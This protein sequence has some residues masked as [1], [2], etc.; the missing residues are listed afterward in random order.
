MIAIQKLRKTHSCFPEARFRDYNIT[1]GTRRMGA[2]FMMVAFLF[3]CC[4][5]GQDEG[6]VRV[7]EFDPYRVKVWVSIAPTVGLSADQQTKLLHD[8]EHEAD[9]SF[10]A[11]WRTQATH[12][13]RSQNHSV[14][15]RLSQVTV[16]E[17][18][19]ADMS[20]VIAKENKDLNSVRTAETVIE[21]VTD[22]SVSGSEHSELE[23]H[24]GALQ[25][26]P[27]W[28]S[29][30]A[31]LKKVTQTSISLLDEVE[32]GKIPCAI[33]RNI[34]IDPEQ[35]SIRKI[36]L[37]LPW[38]SDSILRSFD[39]LFLVSIQRDAQF[40]NVTTREIDCPMRLAGEPIAGNSIFPE[41][42]A[43]VIDNHFVHTFS[44]VVRIEEV[45]S[46]K[47]RM[48][49]RAGGL[50]LPEEHPALV[51]PGDVLMPMVRMDDRNGVPS[52]LDKVPWTY[53]AVIGGDHVKLNGLAISG[54]NGGLDGRQNKRTQRVALRV[55]PNR[56]ETNLQFTVRT[57]KDVVLPGV[58]V[59]E[60]LPTGG[61]MKLVGRSDWRGILSLKETALPEI[62]FDLPTTAGDPT[63]ESAIP[64]TESAPTSA[65]EPVPSPTDQNAATPPAQGKAKV[66]SPATNSTAGS[67]EVTAPAAVT[68]DA[69]ASQEPVKPKG[70]IKLRVPLYL[71]YVRN[72][73]TVLARLPIITG[74]N[75]L[76]IADLPDDR[77]RLEAE[78]MIRGIETEILDAIIRR[79]LLIKRTETYLERKDLAAA[80][81]TLGVLRLSAN[82]D[83]ISERLE[84]VQR[85]IFDQEKGPLP[86]GAAPRIDAMIFQTREIMQKFLQDTSD[87]DLETK[88]SELEA[89][90]AATPEG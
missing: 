4:A 84:A 68:P 33:V 39:K 25:D 69:V 20:L 78:A 34:D 76:E 53:I 82:Y 42:L 46:K 51:V 72:G 32:S 27:L 62:E 66:D 28:G 1:R 35:K 89:S 43:E 17:L 26:L 7:W 30:S 2:S 40:I 85:K 67:G 71:Y 48:R 19:A 59:F 65:P 56:T 41:L 55:R 52:M 16:D 87:R 23:Q 10:G 22:I 73:D 74:L 29:L 75:K 61:D 44:P 15:S 83:R 57:A 90:G 5:I 8:I 14:L 13:P 31:K 49:L 64:P 81:E 45:K 12:T 77:R 47:V 88:V 63:A 79:K 60:R 70:K 24:L 80:K 21:K 6:I 37:R 18:I 50:I 11:A 58:A 86:L 9:I 38:Q 54:V 3:A 36:P